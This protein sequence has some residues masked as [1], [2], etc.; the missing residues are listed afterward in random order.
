MRA[1]QLLRALALSLLFASASALAQTVTPLAAALADPSAIATDGSFLYVGNGRDILRLPIGGGAVT[2]LY[3]GA[4]PCCVNG[5]TLLGTDL[6][7]IDPNGDPDATAIF[8]GPAAGGA[9]TKIFSGFATGQ[10]IVDGAGIT[11]DGVKLYTTDFVQGH[12]HSLNTNG[13]VIALLG[14]RYGGFFDTEHFNTLTQA[15]GLLYIVDPGYNGSITLAPQVLSIPVAGGSFTTLYSGA[16]FVSPRSVAVGNG[17]IYIAD[18]G[19]GN[20]IWQMPVGGGTP[21]VLVAGAPFININS[22]IF[23][24]N[25]LYV[26]DDG[27]AAPGAIY[28]VDLPAG[29]DATPDAFV[30]ADQ[31]GVAL[32]TV[33]VSNAIT[34]SGINAA[35]AIGVS[36]GDYSVNG[37]TFTST[38]GTVTNGQTVQV[39]HTSAATN[40]TTTNTVLTIGGV[41]DTFT[42]TTAAS[43][44]AG[45][46]VVATIPI[47]GQFNNSVVDVN[48]VTNRVY[49]GGGA[50]FLPQSVN[51][52]N[53][54][55]NTIIATLAGSGVAV[56]ST[57]N[58]F[59]VAQMSPSA[60]LAYDGTNNSL[61]ATI[62][63][64]GC[65]H[66]TAVDASL[67]R[68][69]GAAQCG[70]N[71]DPVFSIDGSNNSIL[72][73]IGSGGVMGALKV[74]PA[75][76]TIYIGP[77]G[78][79]KKINHTTYAVSSPPFAGIVQAANPV[80]N[81][82]YA[83]NGSQTEV[84]D[85]ATE[86][87]ITTLAAAGAVAVDTTRNFV[88]VSDG[89][90]GALKVFDGST[91][92]L[93]DSLSLTS[94]GAV[95]V[96]AITGRIYVFSGN[97]LKA[98]DFSLGA[99]TTPDAFTFTD[100]TGVALN[101]VVTSN[102]IT[103]T[104]INAAASI[105][106]SGGEYSIN[107]GTFTAT[108]G[109]VTNGQTV[110]VRHTTAATN[111]TATNT[112]LTVG[113]VSDTFTTITLSTTATRTL[114]SSA[115]GAAGAG[116]I[117]TDGTALYF[118][119]GNNV[120]KMPIGGGVVTTLYA[121]ATPC[122]VNGLTLLG[123]NLYWI[124]PNGD[125]D[126][127]AI[128]K[129]PAAGGAVTKI[130]SG[131]ATGQPI[132]DGTGI[133]NDG[134]KL[135]TTDYVQ[136]RVH[137]LNADGSSIT[138]LGSRYGGFFDTEHFNTLTQAGG[139]LYIVDPGYNGSIT[140]APQVLS[141]PVAGGSFTTLYSGAPF[142][143]PR[144]VAV[145]NGQIYIADPGADNTIWQMP[146]GGGTPTVLV[147]G[148]P[149]I[150][151]NSLIFFN[152]AIYVTDA[153]GIYRVDL[154]AVPAPP[155][156]PSTLSLVSNAPAFTNPGPMATDGINLYVGNGNNVL[157]LPLAGGA[158]VTLFA[159]ATPCC[160]NGLA[161]IGTDLY[162]IDPNGDPD[163]TAIFR[164]LTT[165][166]GVTKIYSGFAS[167]QPIVDGASIA[168]DGTKLFTTD[169]VQGRVHSM[170]A[171]GSG[172]AQLGS[173]YG[174]FFDTEHLNTLT[175]SGG[176][177]YIADSGRAGT[178]AP[179][180]VSIPKAGGAFSVIYSGAP[181]IAP[182]SIAVGNGTIFVADP[183]SGN[184]VWVIPLAGGAPTPLVQGAPF[185]QISGLLFHNNAL[186]VSDTGNLGSF[187]GPGAIYK[188]DLSGNLDTTPNAF[189]FIDQTGVP[190]GTPVQSNTVTITGI[191]S[192]ASISITGGEYS[193]DGLPY[194]AQA[195]TISN[196]QSVTVR[197]TSSVQFTTAINTVLVI[198]GV[199]D[200]FTST[201]VA[202]VPDTV[203]DAFAF[204]PLTGVTVNT[205]VV[206]NAI[207]VTGINT[208]AP[209]S[210]S[211]GQYSVNNGSF[212][213]LAGTVASGQSVVVRVIAA[214][215]FSTLVSAT[216]NI[217]G[218]NAGFNV[219]TEA[220]DTTPDPFSFTQQN[221]V[222]TKSVIVSNTI[223]V[224]GINTATAISITGGEYR[225]GGGAFTS[226]AGTVLNG[227]TVTVRLTS[228][229]AFSTPVS[230][231][232]TIGGVSGIFTAVTA[233]A[234]V[235]AKQSRVAAGAF[236][237][238][239]LKND[240][241]VWSWGDNI[242]G[243]LGTGS[244]LPYGPPAQ[245]SGLTN[246]TALAAGYRHS[247]A[248]RSDGAV[249]AWGDG[250]SGQLG[251][252]S[253]LSRVP[254][255]VAG[256]AVA[257]SVAAGTDHNVAL[258]NDRTVWAWGG[259]TYGQLGNNTTAGSTTPVQVSGLTNVIAIAVRD[260]R[261]FAVTGD[262]NV[263]AW[264]NNADGLLGDGTTANRL[265]PAQVVGISGAVDVA[266]G[267]GF[268]LALINDA[269]VMAWGRNDRGQLGNNSIADST[270]PVP[271]SGLAGASLVAAGGYHGLALKGDGTLWAWGSN[272]AGQLGMV[273]SQI[274][275]CA[276]AALRQ[277]RDTGPGA[278]RREWY[279][280]RLVAQCRS[281]RP[282]MLSRS[283]VTTPS[284][285]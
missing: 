204:V 62:P 233:A 208:P 280:S 115:A 242:L 111:G 154:V 172:I 214:G 128:F 143:S 1:L 61:I 209:I 188:I 85:G 170:S 180:V 59:Y 262:G 123:T 6:Y 68:A 269:T 221:N 255:Q 243:Q 185:V 250:S 177:I 277:D 104:G 140:L 169:F 95:A 32:S 78:V 284:D 253:T 36:G 66:S 264:G 195:G 46:T 228:S 116:P 174:G 232:L 84:I 48:P 92:A 23:F 14:S 178:I 20:T 225:I 176:V 82:L 135:Y 83:Q 40:S 141:I 101:A 216:L 224:S 220:P 212:T 100:Q 222:A 24:N 44:A 131:F 18:P 144:S 45:F 119:S 88:Y 64:S 206:S 67:N 43:G 114:L 96:N 163:A 54:A 122:C 127:T 147:A 80:T 63:V 190:P 165:G 161:R 120:N 151:I 184:T 237:T 211:G 171:D 94:P 266:A 79:S 155:P 50:T 200:T 60:I 112:T 89:N 75:T 145:G 77:S 31:S 258:M 13:A 210:I 90:A 162:W 15:A 279:R 110:Q 33:V 69:Y 146:V 183:G 240:G 47:A 124:D 55:T 109:S 133:T 139:L 187:D 137:S 65:T 192:P 35:A 213:F 130:Y 21:T 186:Y 227:Q 87:V 191:N 105:S 197:H 121:S 138:P 52:I 281:Q 166:G 49:T 199:S 168:T 117:V 260:Y 71:N 34:V 241:T 167:G 198:G 267:S 229:I 248:L 126:A 22:L 152:G 235:L 103:V 53:G 268:T 244:T 51:V 157:S 189:S 107:S 202:A 282:A 160:V 181:L 278:K 38:A 29:I 57:T 106:V 150:N 10:P 205:Q 265:T 76:H 25:A 142:V 238:L 16:P 3:T 58:R 19:A 270:V 81:R 249:W 156:Q 230:A 42:T 234:P 219:T 285:N 239:V 113:G 274:S 226:A 175:E 254:V 158:P 236:H 134:V 93:L 217:G 132:I 7:W 201:T 56:N 231:T 196:G 9:A 11:N 129:G 37:G 72:A 215:T 207:T 203:P 246:I 118:G 276:A 125:P 251:T 164:G 17:K 73:T 257:I 27:G 153:S 245:V 86:L 30:F 4:T 5:L 256:L 28:R 39:R 148:A 252:A 136:G 271:V 173:R 149:F 194:T 108:A 193:I 273:N 99:D 283:G 159:N 259:N 272:E 91:H 275:L 8:K 41:S 98:V 2:T 26:T 182:T 74:N 218:V 263:W 70:S 97:D 12:V 223:T 179:Q 102:P 247:L 261:S